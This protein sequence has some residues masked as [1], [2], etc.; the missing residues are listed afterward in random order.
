MPSEID[1]LPVTQSGPKLQ[2]QEAHAH[3]VKTSHLEEP[4]SPVKE[5][6]LLGGGVLPEG[7]NHGFLC[8]QDGRDGEEAEVVPWVDAV[9]ECADRHG[10]RYSGTQSFDTLVDVLG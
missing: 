9:P 6:L 8:H 4:A 1:G 5:V 10:D 2:Q 7:A 3:V